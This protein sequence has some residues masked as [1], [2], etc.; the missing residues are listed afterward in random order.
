MALI[1]I[2]HCFLLL[3]SI[4]LYEGTTL[5]PFS[6]FQLF[7]NTKRGIVNIFLDVSWDTHA[8][9]LLRQIPRGGIVVSLICT[10]LNLPEKA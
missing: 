6:C 10:T 3:G 1:A 7:A 2:I 8:T 4:S 5:Y 9:D